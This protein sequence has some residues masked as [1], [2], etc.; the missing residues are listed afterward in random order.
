MSKAFYRRAE[1][2]ALTAAALNGTLGVLTHF[3]LNSGIS[4]HQI[5]FWKCFIAFLILMAYCMVKPSERKTVFALRHK[6]LQ[7]AIL[8][9][10]GI[11]CL[12]FFETWAFKEAPIPLVSFLVYA[13]GGIT[14]ILSSLF[15]GEKMGV[16]KCLSFGLIIIGV[17]CLFNFAGQTSGNYTGIVL[18]LLGGLGYAL[19]IFLSKLMNI[20]SGI[21]VLLWLFGFG[22]IYLAIPAIHE[23]LQ[24]PSGIALLMILGLVLLPSI[25]GFYFTTKAVEEGEASSVQIT[26]TSEPLFSTLLAFLIIGETLDWIGTLGALFIMSGLVVSILKKPREPQLISS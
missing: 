12:Y 17:Y 13:S 7:F 18:A 5:A 8:A 24:F 15:L 22:S 11:F 26:E 25:G 16:N 19:F 23:G 9:F 4:H 2:Y 21:S 1:F 14:L 20:G 6:S 3:G 10:F